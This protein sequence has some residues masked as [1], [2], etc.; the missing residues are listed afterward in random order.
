M[1]NYKWSIA[2]AAELIRKAEENCTAK[3]LAK[4]Y[5]GSELITEL[6]RIYALPDMRND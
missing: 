6:E 5:Q 1:D 4:L 2:R 3:K